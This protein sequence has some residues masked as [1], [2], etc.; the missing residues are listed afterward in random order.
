[1][2]KQNKDIYSKERQEIFD[3]II[4][5][6]TNG[7]FCF[8]YSELKNPDLSR[9][10]VNLSDDIDKYFAHDPSRSVPKKKL[11]HL[12]AHY[13]I[14]KVVIEMGY[15]LNKLCK[16]NTKLGKRDG[17]KVIIRNGGTI[18]EKNVSS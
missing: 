13:I 16:Y 17:L 4:H 14:R 2:T 12:F 15:S 11:P 5:R 8:F 10:I 9:D 3:Y 7:T 6:V 1:M 18:K